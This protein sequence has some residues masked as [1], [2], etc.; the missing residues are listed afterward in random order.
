MMLD[1]AFKLAHGG[2]YQE[3]LSHIERFLPTDPDNTTA[4][5]LK[6]QMLLQLRR[7]TEALETYCRLVRLNRADPRSW[8][9]LGHALSAAGR[10]GESQR[11]F[12]KALS[13]ELEAGATRLGLTAIL[14]SF[15]AGSGFVADLDPF[16]LKPSLPG[17]FIAS[18]P[19]SG[20]VFLQDALCHGLDKRP[21][22]VPSAGLFPNVMLAQSAVEQ[23]VATGGVY[24]IHVR[25]SDFNRIEIANRLDRMIVHVRDL[26]QALLSWVMFL[27]N[28]LK[29][30]DP[31]QAI[32]YALP[33]A[34]QEWPLE[35]QIDWQIENYLPQQ[36]AWVGDWLETSKDAGFPTRVMFTTQEGLKQDQKAF[37][38]RLLDFLGIDAARFKMP[39][40]PRSGQSNF[41]S[42]ATDEWR[43]VFTN[44][45][46][47]KATSMMPPGL[48]AA[49][50][51]QP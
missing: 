18:L 9:C 12:F 42:G 51:W 6:G 38:E 17:I 14:P 36:I 10:S 34:Y 44:E 1:Q 37:F 41:R 33:K 11:T 35:K 25:P 16:T 21:V 40:P 20:T 4:I 47:G 26:R 8:L 43:H 28:V 15:A 50:G 19:K 49:F 46:A 5:D 23:V 39:N 31:V 30:V 45:Q 22:A 24:V 27:P 2:Q 48:F 29:N 7:N 3:A 32:H 13:L